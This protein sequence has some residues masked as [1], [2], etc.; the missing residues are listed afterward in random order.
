MRILPTKVHCFEP[1]VIC[2]LYLTF[3]STHQSRFK[4][5]DQTR[6]LTL[7]SHRHYLH[8]YVINVRDRPRCN[9]VLRGILLRGNVPR[10]RDRRRWSV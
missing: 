8:T 5:Q 2:S 10:E 4:G 1:S 9:M 3:E 6:D 7:Y